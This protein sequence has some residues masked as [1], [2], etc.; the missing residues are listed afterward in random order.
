VVS[1]R[2]AVQVLA[3]WRDP[4]NTQARDLASG[5]MVW[6]DADSTMG[7]VAAQMMESYVRHLLVEDDGLLVG[8]VSTRDILGT[9]VTANIDPGRG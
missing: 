3:D 2:D 5:D 6:C 7:E 1:E 4:A 8:V 9:F